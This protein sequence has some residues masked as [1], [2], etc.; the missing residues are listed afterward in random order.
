M[1]DVPLWVQDGVI[2]LTVIFAGLAF[3]NQSKQLKQ[4][5]KDNE[6]QLN[7]LRTQAKGQRTDNK[8]QIGILKGQLDA[9][10]ELNA[11]QM[12]VL[13]LQANELV[14]IS[15]ERAREAAERRQAQ[16]ANV[17]LKFNLT[18]KGIDF[19]GRDPNITNYQATVI[20]RSEQPIYEVVVHWHEG[21]NPSNEDGSNAD[22]MDILLP[23]T[24]K[25]W[26]HRWPA[27]EPHGEPG[28]VVDFRDAAG[29]RWRRMTDGNLDD[30]NHPSTN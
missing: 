13:A 3:W 27:N 23:G 4:D 18:P 2:A 16:A 17:I 11:E 6:D 15:K 14:T 29:L 21:S 10:R 5:K 9:Q 7:Q 19:G 1:S 28:A 24:H 12:R 8:K 20:N 22:S 26:T 30:L 25:V